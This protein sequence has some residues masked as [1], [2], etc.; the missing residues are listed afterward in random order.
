MAG[1]ATFEELV[2]RD[3]AVLKIGELAHQPLRWV[4]LCRHR[5]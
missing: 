4:A 3:D 5:R 2:A 1:N